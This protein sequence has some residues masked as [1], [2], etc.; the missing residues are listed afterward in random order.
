M[1]RVVVL[2][3]LCVACVH[4]P[5]KAKRAVAEINIPAAASVPLAPE[6]VPP[7]VIA[8]Q[9]QQQQ[10]QEPTAEPVVAELPSEFFTHA[11]VHTEHPLVKKWLHY[12]TVREHKLVSAFSRSRRVLSSF[13]RAAVGGA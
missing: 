3:L 7:A 12:F 2:L 8:Q 1:R 9:Q 11:M 10:P 6:P 4:A 5:D 13:H